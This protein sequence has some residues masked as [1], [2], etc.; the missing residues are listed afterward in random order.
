MDKHQL[1]QII[2]FVKPYYHDKKMGKFHDWRHILMVLRAAEALADDRKDLNIYL[3]KASCYIHDIGRVIDD[4]THPLQSIKIVTPFL[5]QIGIS[6]QGILT[7]ADAVLNHGIE[8]IFKSKTKEAKVLFDADKL[9]IISIYGFMRVWAWLVEERN[10]DIDKAIVFLHK[11]VHAVKDKYLQTDLA[12]KI[13]KIEIQ[14]IDSL[15]ADW[16]N[17]NGFNYVEK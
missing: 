13:A 7:I 3:L 8:N 6:N 2:Q 16:K 1:D 10:M 17:W 5:Q 12:K 9:Q 14:K 4:D 15:V 11:Y